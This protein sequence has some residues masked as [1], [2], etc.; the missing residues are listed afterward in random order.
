MSLISNFL[1]SIII[2]YY[3]FHIRG[4][5]QKLINKCFL[6]NLIAVYLFINN[7]GKMKNKG[8][9]TVQWSYQSVC[10]GKKCLKHY[11]TLTCQDS[12]QTDSVQ[13]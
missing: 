9:Q 6:C 7:H 10:L 3:Y 4:F 12:R 11:C 2:Y 5:F 13:F 1:K 8:S